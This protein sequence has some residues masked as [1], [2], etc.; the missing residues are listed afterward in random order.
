MWDAA[1]AISAIALQMQ[2]IYK[3]IQSLP[4]KQEKE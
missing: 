3:E 1:Q 4:D 2:S